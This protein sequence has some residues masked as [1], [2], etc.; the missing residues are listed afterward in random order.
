MRDYVRAVRACFAAFR[1]GRGGYEG[2]FY[3]IRRPVFQPS[4][5]EGVSEPPVYVAAV[6]PVMTGVCGEVGDGLAAHPFTTAEYLRDVLRPALAAGARRAG[7]APP[8]VLP[9]LVGPPTRARLATKRSRYTGPAN[10]R[11]FDQAGSARR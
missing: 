5:D 2:D 4:A 6:N 8:P 11:A 7:G 9:Q 10:R 3:R 1:T